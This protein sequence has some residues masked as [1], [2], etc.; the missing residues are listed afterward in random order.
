M[1]GKIIISIMLATSLLTGCSSDKMTKEDSAY[2]DRVRTHFQ[3]IDN[4]VG[5]MQKSFK[6][7]QLGSAIWRDNLSTSVELV[8]VLSETGKDLKPTKKLEKADS[9]YK[10][11][12]D[13]YG[14]M[15]DKIH[16]GFSS[17]VSKGVD[18]SNTEAKR[19]FD[20][21]AVHMNLADAELGVFAKEL[22]KVFP[23]LDKK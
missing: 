19:K 18:A 4:A 3:K 6:D 20:E 5:V 14:I 15:E 1:K 13:E 16:E 17:L 7:I 11:A 9:H 22:V 21:A 23:E 12:M 2:L 10:K 8:G